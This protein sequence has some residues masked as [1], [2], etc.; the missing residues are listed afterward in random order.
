MRVMT[1][2]SR[3]IVT[4]LPAALLLLS[5]AYAGDDDIKALKKPPVKINFNDVVTGDEAPSGGGTCSELKI[6]V[7]AMI[8]P[9]YTYNF[10]IDL[11]RLIG[12]QVGRRVSL[13]Q[14]K[15]YSEVNEMLRR[16]E[17][18]LAFVCS[19][20]YVA[21]KKKF[22]MEI[23]AVPVCHG[24]KVYHSLFIT[25]K[26]SG[27]KSFDDLRG[28]TFVFTDPLSNT[29]YMVPIYYLARRNETPDSYFKK[30]FFSYSHDNSIQAVA[31]GLADGAAVDSL[32]YAFMQVRKPLL[33]AETKVI[34]RSPPY[35]IPPVVVNPSLAPG[36][37]ERLKKIFTSI[38]EN[39][40]GKA[41]LKILQID[42]FV[43]GHDE[44]YDTVREL[45]RFIKD[46]QRDDRTL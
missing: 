23:I 37:K 29:G 11:L 7:A 10:Y 22:G 6:A 21:G 18:D 39:P 33:T 32:I 14:K 44:D 38:H 13:V 41:I 43:E 19:G 4:A 30:T 25:S 31:D 3:I 34:E 1:I 16:N 45:Q 26:N 28:K 8:S 24:Q 36:M 12:E 40:K 20:P 42:R 5:P 17:L 35:G 27:I 9:K 15:T 46:R 2:I